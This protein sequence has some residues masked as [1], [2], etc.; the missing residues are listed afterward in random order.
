MRSKLVITHFMGPREEF[1]I[2]R[3][4]YNIDYK[5]GRFNQWRTITTIRRKLFYVKGFS[6][7]FSYE[8]HW[9]FPKFAPRF[10]LVKEGTG[11]GR[12]FLNKCLE[13]YITLGELDSS[14]LQTLE[15]PQGGFIVWL[16]LMMDEAVLFN[17]SIAVL[18]INWLWMRQHTIDYRERSG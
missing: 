9:G 14:N 7:T 4:R 16:C 15:F 10:C 8:K 1:V 3:F 5:R 11:R 18:F 13:R 12:H 6:K 17:Q 2:S